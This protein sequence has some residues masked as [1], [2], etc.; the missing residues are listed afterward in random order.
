MIYFIRDEA[1]QLIKIGFTAAD[2]E[3][4]LRTLQT[5]CPGKLVLLLHMEGSEQDE[6]AWHERFVDA[7]E[8]GE[9]FTPVPELLLAIME[10]RVL[11]L[12]SENARLLEELQEECE[13]RTMV[14]A[15]LRQLVCVHNMK[16]DRFT[17]D[18]VYRFIPREKDPL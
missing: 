18:G 13:Q 8:R 4:R 10:E 15:E 12:E 17:K 6:A 9:W 2:V 7:R 16:G 11:Q 5:G 14:E 3:N 1:T